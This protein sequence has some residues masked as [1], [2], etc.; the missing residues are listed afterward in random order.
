MLTSFLQRLTLSS[1]FPFSARCS[2]TDPAH[3]P[4][5]PLRLSCALNLLILLASLVPTP[6]PEHL[7]HDCVQ[8]LDM[9]LN[10]FEHI[11]GQPLTGSKVPEYW[12][13]DGSAQ[14]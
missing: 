9:T 1:G 5:R 4:P 14:T 13:I 10:P 7:S 2:T 6:D 12:F 3:T 8:A 11:T